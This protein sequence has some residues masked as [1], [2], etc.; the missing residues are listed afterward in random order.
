MVLLDFVEGPHYIEP[1]RNYEIDDDLYH[2]YRI[3]AQHRDSVNLEMDGRIA[4][5]H[6]I[7]CTSNSNE[8]LDH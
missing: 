5:D 6:K 2:I 8:E 4:W 1:V 3:T 7:S